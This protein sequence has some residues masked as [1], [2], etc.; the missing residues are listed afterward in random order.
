MGDTL[1]EVGS[2]TPSNFEIALQKLRESGFEV[3]ATE[4][5]EDDSPELLEWRR[6]DARLRLFSAWFDYNRDNFFPLQLT[7]SANGVVTFVLNSCP[8]DP[9]SRK[10]A[11]S[12]LGT[13]ALGRLG[14]GQLAR[15]AQMLRALP[16]WCKNVFILMHHAPYRRPG[17]WRWRLTV[18][19]IQ[20]S[21]LLTCNTVEARDFLTLLVEQAHERGEINFCLFCGH[22]HTPVAAYAGRVLI[23]EGASLAE[24][25][26][27]AWRGIPD[28]HKIRVTRE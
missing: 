22:R 6:E 20:E 24:A 19:E 9:R 2:T 13:S 3:G 1:K 25:T 21:A 27:S 18:K 15:L 8:D 14:P 4:A 7:D 5:E 17:Q 28:N 23:L 12:P 10:V 11:P 16:T 26:A